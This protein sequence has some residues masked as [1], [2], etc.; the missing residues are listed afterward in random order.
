MEFHL[1]YRGALP[2]CTQQNNRVREKHAIR[3]HFHDQLDELWKLDPR[4]YS[5]DIQKLQIGELQGRVVNVQRPIQ[6][7]EKFFYRIPM[8]GYNFIP[9]IPRTLELACHLNIMIL[10]RENPG[11]IIDGGDLDN[12][13]KTLF[14]ALRIPHREDELPKESGEQEPKTCLCLLEDDGLITK[15]SVETERL[16]GPKREDERDTDIE[17]QIHVVVKAVHPMIGNLDWLY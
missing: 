3:L 5:I 11:S 6:G 7:P 9:I 12:R 8:C 13:L 4:L 15:L 2:A 17:L 14:D 1:R 10:R 16:L